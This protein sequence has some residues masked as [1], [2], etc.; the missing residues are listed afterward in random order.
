MFSRSTRP[1]ND[2]I[3][4]WLQA[5]GDLSNSGAASRGQPAQQGQCIAA[6]LVKLNALAAA[7]PK[8]GAEPRHG[9]NLLSASGDLQI[10]SR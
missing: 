2:G 1:V 5:F 9:T 3:D 8:T 6:L 4:A 7:Y 10:D